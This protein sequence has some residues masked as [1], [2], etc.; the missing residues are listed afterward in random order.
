MLYEMLFNFAPFHGKSQIEVLRNMKSLSWSRPVSA[1]MKA[2][3]TP[4][5]WDLLMVLLKP[6]PRERITWNALVTHPFVDRT[7]LVTLDIPHPPPIQEETES[8]FSPVSSPIKSARAA[9]PAEQLAAAAVAGPSVVPSRAAEHEVTTLP[10]TQPAPIPLNP[11]GSSQPI[12]AHQRVPS[13][14]IHSMPRVPSSE[15]LGLV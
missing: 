6:N 7:D 4:S 2:S 12:V 13:S 5:T 14:E 15:N 3:I 11:L 1:T 10:V 9:A 8:E